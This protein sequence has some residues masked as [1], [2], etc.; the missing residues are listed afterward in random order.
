[1][2]KKTIYTVW[3]IFLNRWEKMNLKLISDNTVCILNESKKKVQ[4]N[5]SPAWFSD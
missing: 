1:M 3:K 4:S 2:N 5:Y